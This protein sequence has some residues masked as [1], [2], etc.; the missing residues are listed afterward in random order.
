MGQMPGM[1]NFHGLFLQTS[2]SLP[3]VGTR[4]PSSAHLLQPA[5]PYTNVPHAEKG[6]SKAG[7]KIRFSSMISRHWELKQDNARIKRNMKNCKFLL[8]LNSFPAGLRTK[9]YIW[10]FQSQSGNNN[11]GNLVC[12]LPIFILQRGVFFS[13]LQIK[14]SSHHVLGTSNSSSWGKEGQKTIWRS[15]GTR[16]T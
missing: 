5:L 2:L 15:S 6:S 16:G 9:T 13:L 1:H 3:T 12:C 10:C 7:A 8:M 14:N 11:N 4:M